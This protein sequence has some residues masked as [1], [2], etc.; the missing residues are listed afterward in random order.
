MPETIGT[1]ILTVADLV[2]A[3]GDLFVAFGTNTILGV[4]YAQIIGTTV[5]VAGELAI[6]YAMLP[7]SPKIDGSLSIQQPVPFRRR[8]YGQ[9]KMGGAIIFWTSTAGTLYALTAIAAH[10][11]DSFLEYWVGDRRVAIDGNGWVTSVTAPPSADPDQFNPNYPVVRIATSR[12]EPGKVANALLTA[13]FPGV[14]TSACVG[15]GIADALLITQS[16]GQDAFASVY[17]GGIQN[18]RCL[19]KAARIYDVL[20][21]GSPAQDPDDPTTWQWSDNSVNVVLDYL[22]HADG[23]RMDKDTFLTGLGGAVTLASAAICDEV[24]P[25][26]SGGSEKRYRLWG[27]YD[28]NEEPRQVLARMLASFGGWLQPFADGTIGIRAG[29]WVA[30]TFTITDDMILAFE[31]QHF[32]GEFDAVNEIRATFLDSNND[33]QNSESTPWQDIA[34]IARRGYIKSTSIDAR[35]CPTYTQCRRIQKIGMHEASPDFSISLTCS[36][37]AVAG[38]NQKFVTLN[39][40]QLGISGNFRVTAF[41]VNLVTAVCQISLASFDSDAFTWD[42]DTEEGDA[43][44]IPPDSSSSNP[45]D[46]PQNLTVVVETATIAGAA[47]GPVMVISCDP[48]STRTDLY[49]KFEYQLDG[50]ARWTTLSIGTQT[51]ETQT[52]IL[53]D[54]TYNVRASFLTPVNTRFPLIPDAA[55][56]SFVLGVIVSASAAAPAAPSGIAAVAGSPASVV[57]ISFTAPN[58]ASF[59]AGRVYR[60]S[61]S[62]FGTAT[63]VSG[64]IYGSPN[65]FLS[66]ED[67]PGAGTWYYWATA[68]SGTGN[69][70]SPDGPVS[71]VV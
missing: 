64:P 55:G 1:L 48:P 4:T 22:T 6:S 2:F 50:E 68:E 61:V 15:V 67:S 25:L 70:S 51:Y 10:E 37:A 14:W 40:S 12:G 8:V 23:W 5:L 71:I 47:V 36:I 16:V 18:L 65:Q 62:T 35:H 46:V 45:G 3:T 29:A 41:S 19:I 31:V 39:M 42:P 7:T 27:F 11:I 17:P 43:P 49:I 54:G 28:F 21:A 69:A 13:A 30:P 56:F 32:V 26:K 24:V 9:A 34:D 33:Y 44:P 53:P 63:D 60:N 20:F 58:S 52:S 59:A 38:R 66:F 57:V